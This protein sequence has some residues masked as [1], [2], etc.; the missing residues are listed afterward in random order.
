MAESR[1]QAESCAKRRPTIGDRVLVLG[2]GRHKGATGI[3]DRDDHTYIPFRANLDTGERG[4]W[5]KEDQVELIEDAPKRRP[6]VGDRVR[7]GVDMDLSLEG[8]EG[9]IEQDDRSD[10]PYKVN[11]GNGMTPWLRQSDVEIIDEPKDPFVEELRRARVVYASSIE[12][13]LKLLAE[14][15]AEDRAEQPAPSA[16]DILA[17]VCDFIATAFDPQPK[18]SAMEESRRRI[19]NQVLLDLADRFDIRIDSG[20]MFSIDVH[21]DE[22]API[23]AGAEYTRY[24]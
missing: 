18:P 23:V 8:K 15:E 9:V 10:V 19:A 22:D 16:K 20:K 11:L 6:T 5:F 24:V 3:I 2:N 12:E 14:M 7:V 21:T 17:N 1:D 4:A 13:G